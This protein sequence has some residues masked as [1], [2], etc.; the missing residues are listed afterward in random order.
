[1]PKKK[2]SWFEQF[3]EIL[4]PKELGKFITPGSIQEAN[5]LVNELPNLTLSDGRKI[6]KSVNWEGY[7]LWWMH[8]DE[9]MWKFCI[10]HTQY[11]DLLLY[12]K[13]FNNVYLY[14][15]PWPLLFQYFLRAYNRHCLIVGRFQPRNLSPIPLGVFVQTILSIGSLIW[16]KITS[17][18]LMVFTGDKFGYPH[19]YD[20]R[21]KSVYEELKKKRVPFVEFIRSLESWQ[22]I[23]RHAWRRKRP[24]IYSAAIIDV[25][26]SIARRFGR[27]SIS[28]PKT[29]SREEYFWSLVALHFLHN[30]RGTIWSIQA[31]KFILQWIGVKSAYICMG[32]DRTFHELLG[33]KLAGIK[34]V[35]IQHAAIPRYACIADF[36]PGFDG[37]KMLS[38]DRYGLWSD[39]WRGYYLKY[40]Q[41]Y[42]PDQLFVSGPSRPLD[43]EVTTRNILQSKRDKLKVLFVSE[44]LAAPPEVLPFLL[45]LLEV[46]D[47]TISIKFRP[48]RDGFEVWLRKHRP[49]ILEK[50][51]IFRGSPQQAAAQS[52][53]VVGSHS[54]AVLEGLLQ[55]KPI[56]F[57]WTNK[58]GD[59]FDLKDLGMEKRFFALN[60]EE[61]V[62]YVRD[63]HNV[64]KDIIEKLQK[65]FF[66]DPSK[67]GGKWV[68][69]QALEFA[70]NYKNGQ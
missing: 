70:K 24:V 13:D 5:R 8:Y 51:K 23:L 9:L 35:G 62:D 57:F 7:E 44:Q 18:E 39:W 50:V 37:S 31:M 43:K 60:P 67:N 69:E 33:C 34:S 56:I 21:L 29:D 2:K 48:Y 54:S 32:C 36:M 55:K 58:W 52:D 3:D 46:D 38:V 22:T 12:L 63:S 59:Y 26:H 68:V 19:D 41:A 6:S 65:R 27:F 45:K 64:P 40:G 10:P 66:G 49:D 47:F 11:R 16:L 28:L 20:F 17:P 1:M 25:L 15:S 53:V 61:L 14:Q 30:I 4:G 42:K